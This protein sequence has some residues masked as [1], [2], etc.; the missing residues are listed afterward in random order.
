MIQVGPDALARIAFGQRSE[1]VVAV[2][3]APD[4]SL[5]RLDADRGLPAEPLLAVLEAV[6]KPG[7]VGAILRSADGAGL[8]AV[9]LADPVADP[10]NPNTIRSSLGTVFTTRLAV[11]SSGETL[12]WLSDRGI[13]II[14]ARVDGA[15][16]WDVADLRGG[17]AICL[18]SEARGLTPAWSGP[19]IEAV[20]LPMLGRADSLNVAATAAV[21]FYE[22]RRQ[23]R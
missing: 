13:R 3:A 23:R 16:S 4:R 11:A 19:E 5:A 21:L 7:N 9:I 2:V 15:R 22:A 1:G 18:G 12:G 20:R 6:E 8:D 10:W 17:L 14:A